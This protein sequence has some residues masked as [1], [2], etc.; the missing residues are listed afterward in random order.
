MDEWYIY[1]PR[2]YFATDFAFMHALNFLKIM[3]KKYLPDTRDNIEPLTLSLEII[4]K[5]GSNTERFTDDILTVAPGLPNRKGP[6]LEKKIITEGGEGGVYC[7]MYPEHNLDD[8]V[9]KVANPEA[10]TKEQ[11]LQTVHGHLEPLKQ[12]RRYPTLKHDYQESLCMR[13]SIAIF[14]YLQLGAREFICSR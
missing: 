10:T 1:N 6:R 7:G 13:P 3:I 11:R 14:I 2:A 8:N 5:Y 4:A 9:Q 12:Y